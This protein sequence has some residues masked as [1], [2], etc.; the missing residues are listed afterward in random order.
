[1]KK[2]WEE[3]N[4]ERYYEYI[5]KI[6]QERGQWSVKEHR[7]RHHIILKCKGGL[8]EKLSECHHS[9]VI[10]L[11]HFEHMIAHLILA[12]DNLDDFEVCL[13]AVHFKKFCD[14]ECIEVSSL[15]SNTYNSIYSAS[16]SRKCEANGMFGRSHTAESMAKMSLNHNKDAY[17]TPEFRKKRSDYTKLCHWYTNGDR[18]TFS[19]TCPDGWWRGRKQGTSAK[20]KNAQA[21]PTAVYDSNKALVGVFGSLIEASNAV[22]FDHS[23][24]GHVKGFEKDYKGFYF[25]YLTKEGVILWKSCL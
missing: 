21:K 14:R 13:A 2:S 4:T 24:K 23:C 8:P 7:S 6:I 25:R 11:T 20:S 17:K 1:M 19:L 12:E 10:W 15:D 5:N 16:Q 18:E 22:G 3:L 9:N